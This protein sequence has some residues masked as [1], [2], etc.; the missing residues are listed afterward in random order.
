MKAFVALYMLFAASFQSIAVA[1]EGK[2][3]SA[4]W[5]YLSFG[6]SPTDV[7]K[8]LITQGGNKILE[9]T[10][11]NPDFSDVPLQFPPSYYKQLPNYSDYQ[12]LAAKDKEV[13]SHWR[14]IFT[15]ESS[16]G[17]WGRSRKWDDKVGVFNIYL[18]AGPSDKVM[19]V[20]FVG[21]KLSGITLKTELNPCEQVLS[22][23]PQAKKITLPREAAFVNGRGNPEF[24]EYTEGD[25]LITAQCNG[26]NGG[27]GYQIYIYHVPSLLDAGKR[28]E[29][30]IA[31][32]MS[33][34]KEKNKLF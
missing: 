31:D 21:E 25:G 9:R 27:G 22:R 14:D 12:G 8:A 10:G 4:G 19:S 29:K 5:Q 11:M 32:K 15:K 20:F 2:T 30:L 28:I 16:E 17:R 1:D 24:V 34:T 26:G 33:A 18:Y 6:M 23:Y 3:L 13:K 7:K